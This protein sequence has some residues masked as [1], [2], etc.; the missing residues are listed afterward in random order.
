MKTHA[1]IENGVVMEII[2]PMTYDDGTEI[3][4]DLRFPANVVGA[5]VDVTSQDPM[6][7]DWWI[8]DGATFA[9]SL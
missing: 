6:P 1:R 4:I 3:P 8:Y 9:P 2:K 7:C 5:L